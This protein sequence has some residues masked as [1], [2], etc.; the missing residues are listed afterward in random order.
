[1]ASETYDLLRAL[2]DDLGRLGDRLAD[3]EFS[4]G[5]TGRSPIGR[6]SAS[7]APTGILP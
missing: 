5:S 4:T 7:A 6:G 3:E 1:M 2:R